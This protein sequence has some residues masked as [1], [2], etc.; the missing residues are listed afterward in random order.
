MKIREQSE[1]KRHGSRAK[2]LLVFGQSLQTLGPWTMPI[3]IWAKPN[4]DPEAATMFH[5]RV[6]I[7]SRWAQTFLVGMSSRLSPNQ[8]ASI[9]LQA[10]ACGFFSDL[11]SQPWA[12][13]SEPG[14]NRH[15]L[16]RSNLSSPLSDSPS[17]R[18]YS[19]FSSS[20]LMLCSKIS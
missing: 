7:M 5:M 1:H 16:G 6:T 15:W 8:K 4:M 18:S 19:S 9:S 20:S 11:R 12:S 10:R 2:C 17:L 14:A 13:E 3:I